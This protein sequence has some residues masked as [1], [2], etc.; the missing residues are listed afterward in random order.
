MRARNRRSLRRGQDLRVQEGLLV[1]ENPFGTSQWELVKEEMGD[2]PV[3]FEHG[4]TL[5]QI[6]AR[7]VCVHDAEQRAD[8]AGRCDYSETD[9]RHVRTPGL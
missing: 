4:N 2:S 7:D 1:F 8:E 6:V 5:S 3:V 9:C